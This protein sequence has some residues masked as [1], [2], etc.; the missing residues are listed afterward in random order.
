MSL[1]AQ[2]KQPNLASTGLNGKSRSDGTL[3]CFQFRKPRARSQW[4]YRAIQAP[5]DG[6]PLLACC[7]HAPAAGFLGGD[8]VAGKCRTTSAAAIHSKVSCGPGHAS[9][10][11]PIEPKSRRIGPVQARTSEPLF[12]ARVLNPKG[13]KPLCIVATLALQAF[14]CI[15]YFGFE[16]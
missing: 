1:D 13:V 4:V 2:S 12:S 15:Y 11:K 10:S 16:P 3:R 8:V 6:I 5:L 14:R 7:R 9:A